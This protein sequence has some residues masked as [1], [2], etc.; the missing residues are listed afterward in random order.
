VPL[1]TTAD[2]KALTGHY[3]TQDD[4]KI[5]DLIPRAQ[6]AIEGWTQRQ[7]DA[8][9]SATYSF[10]VDS[11]LVDLAPRELRVASSVTLHPGDTDALVVTAAD[12][13]LDPVEGAYGSTSAAPTYLW[14]RLAA[15]VSIASNRLSRFG[16][17]RIS[18]AG[19]WGL[20]AVPADVT[21]ACALTV[22]S[23]IDRAVDAYALEAQP[24]D[25]RVAIPG[26]SRG[27]SIPEG[28]RRLL[29][30]FRRLGA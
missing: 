12:Y 26:T 18:I 3:G 4:A 17:T 10:A 24:E 11:H 9:A 27:Y 7:L 5:A 25:P 23:W 8:V 30:P 13:D 16:R 21:Q 6:A 1:C 22:A 2:V 19:T 28:A 14:L 20:A 29:D 15:D